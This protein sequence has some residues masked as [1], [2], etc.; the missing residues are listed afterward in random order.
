MSDLDYLFRDFAARVRE[1]AVL[2][3]VHKAFGARP[4]VGHVPSPVER[5]IVEPPLPRVRVQRIEEMLHEA[6]RDALNRVER[7][8]RL[9]STPYVIE[10]FDAAIAK[11]CGIILEA[12]SKKEPLR[13]AEQMRRDLAAERKAT[14][15]AHADELRDARRKLRDMQAAILTAERDVAR[16]R[17][18]VAYAGRPYPEPPPAVL[19]PHR[20]GEGLPSEPGVYFLWFGNTVEYV[21]KSI[22]LAGRLK[23]GSHHV[24]KPDHMISYVLLEERLLTWA[25][26]YYIGTLQPMAN[27]GA[28][29]SHNKV[30]RK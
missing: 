7:K 28:S 20:D 25:E 16:A 18:S 30:T 10:A 17:A 1:Q 9:A 15:K 6:A 4:L 23:L 21:G 14:R 26:C 12:A 29:A 27:F 22:R 8:G 2:P 13:R 5:E 19:R 24:L 11:R 3:T